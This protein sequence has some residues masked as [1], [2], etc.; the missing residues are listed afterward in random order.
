MA[1]EKRKRTSSASLRLEK[2]CPLAS[3]VGGIVWDDDGP[4]GECPVCGG[5]GVVSLSR[6]MWF[7]FSEAKKE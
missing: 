1:E 4:A 6:W 7:T 2:L 3:C 5:T